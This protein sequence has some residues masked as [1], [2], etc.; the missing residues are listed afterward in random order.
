MTKSQP[1]FL[2]VE[3]DTLSREVLEMILKRI[4]NYQNLEFFT[5][6]NNFMDNLRRLPQIPDVI[7]LD[8]SLRPNNGYQVLKWIRADQVYQAV[9]V[10]A[11]TASV[12]VH[13]VQ[14]LQ[15]AGFDGLIGKPIAHKVFPELLDNILGGEPVWYIP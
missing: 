9:K 3:D 15:E 5:N 4:M 12:M 1:F 8:I 10:V 6:S 13:D 14:R 11:L 7:F 2:Y